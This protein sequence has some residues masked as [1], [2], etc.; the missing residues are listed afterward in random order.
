MVKESF[1]FHCLRN[2]EDVDRYHVMFPIM[3]LTSD[4]GR[5]GLVLFYEF[6]PNPVNMSFY[7]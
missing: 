3:S 2:T 5:N 7:L 4:V 1:S 6:L